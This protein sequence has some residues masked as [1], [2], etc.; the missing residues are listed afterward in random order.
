[1]QLFM[2]AVFLKQ[3]IGYAIMIRVCTLYRNPRNPDLRVLRLFGSWQDGGMNGMVVD[4]SLYVTEGGFTWAV[5]VDT[6]TFAGDTTQKQALFAG[7]IGRYVHFA[8]AIDLRANGQPVAGE[9]VCC[10]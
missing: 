4:Y 9:E 2:E 5:T 10:G 7:K 6:G 1:M 3:I 8:P